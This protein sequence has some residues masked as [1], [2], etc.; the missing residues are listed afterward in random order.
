MNNKI[1][2]VIAVLSLSC[3]TMASMASLGAQY[4]YEPFISENVENQA[5]EHATDQYAT[6]PATVYHGG[7]FHQYYCSTGDLTDMYLAHYSESRW[8]AIE[9]SLSHIRYRYSKNG[10]VWSSP[11]IVITQSPG[12]NGEKGACN[13]AIVYDD[14]DG[15][16]YLLYQGALKNY[17]GA[18]YVAR[19]RTL[20]GP[21]EKLSM[22]GTTQKWDR[23]TKK[24]TP[25]LKKKAISNAIEPKAYGLG[26]IS[27]VRHSGKFHIWFNQI[28]YDKFLVYNNNKKVRYTKRFHVAV[29]KITDLLDMDMG[30]TYDDPVDSRI[31]IVTHYYPDTAYDDKN[32]IAYIFNASNSEKWHYS[33]F[34]D[35]RWNATNYGY[36]V[37]MP[38]RSLGY[39][40]RIK[41]Y[42]SIDGISWYADI[43]SQNSYNII[44]QN[45]YWAWL[46]DFG[47]A[48]DSAGN[49]YNKRRLFSF[50]APV[51]YNY[52]DD[53]D[54]QNKGYITDE[55]VGITHGMWPMWELLDGA[56]WETIDINYQIE[57]SFG[58]SPDKKLKFFVGDFDGDGIDELGAVEK[59]S[60]GMLKW[61]LQSSKNPSNNRQSDTWGK[62]WSSIAVSGFTDTQY[63]LI[64]GDYDGDGKTD[65]GVVVYR[66]EN[67]IWN[68]YWRIHSSKTG[69]KGVPNIPYNL[70]IVNLYPFFVPIPG[71][72]DGDGITDMALN[73]FDSWTITSTKTYSPLNIRAL[74]GSDDAC[75]NDL[76]FQGSVNDQG[77][78]S[79][80]LEDPGLD[81]NTLYAPIVNDFDGDHITDMAL[82]DPS[83]NNIYIRSSQTGCHLKFSYTPIGKSKQVYELWPY[84]L[85]KNSSVVGTYFTGDFDGDGIGDHMILNESTGASEIHLS[86]GGAW[87][88]KR[89]FPILKNLTSKTILV[90]DF[91]GNGYS[92]ICII[93]MTNYKYYFYAFGDDPN[94][95]N[96]YVLPYIPR[97]QVKYVDY[98]PSHIVY[99][100]KAIK[101]AEPEIEQEEAMPSFDAYVQDHK[102][103]V[104][105]TLAGQKVVVFDMRGKEIS[106]KVSNG[107]DLT[108]DIPT[109]GTY[110]V[111]SGKSFRKI[112]IK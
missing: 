32:T 66:Y 16:W 39:M 91:D 44:H 71:D 34:G 106:R 56:N 48:G 4:A 45:D 94:N 90:G 92:D 59:L 100:K 14:R 20:R 10:S 98:S 43:K 61:Y 3:A 99:A 54:L 18:I 76:K 103:V 104:S 84:E 72:F 30:D 17:G 13:P 70:K 8:S 77:Y 85:S 57:N 42:I 63:K 1:K 105:N 47:V 24:P 89:T 5:K 25:I 53:E 87:I 27:V 38:D 65:Y 109:K 35:V 107:M 96:P 46:Q 9:N 36:E 82:R 83:T 52:Y 62:T 111:R 112:S 101:P 110:I 55:G 79:F 97:T 81:Y 88:E 69:E 75:N 73:W 40:M 29:D 68:A 64:P 21:F 50:S 80:L 78:Y 28:M 41:K 15:Y 2:A 86:R 102:L 22:D 93:D 60:N 37:W 67:N 108:F 26:Q 23:W 12:S 31:N 19:S 7:Y 33:D 74:T 58:V 6:A 49:I 51:F 95:R 11:S